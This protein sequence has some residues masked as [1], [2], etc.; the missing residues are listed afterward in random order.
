MCLKHKY[1]D[2]IMY[3]KNTSNNDKKQSYIFLITQHTESDFFFFLKKRWYAN[4]SI[5]QWDLLFFF[6]TETILN[7]LIKQI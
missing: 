6:F 3:W 1:Y 4:R 5:S 2:N 7:T